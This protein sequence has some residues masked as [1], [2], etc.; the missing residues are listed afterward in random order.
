VVSDVLTA[1]AVHEV[2]RAC[3]TPE[4][5]TPGGVMVEGI[6][7]SAV[8]DPAK[9]AAHGE[10]I[11]ALLAELP[12]Q[13]RA[14][15]GGGWSFLNACDDRHGNQWTGFHRSMEELFMVGM[16][17]GLVRCLMPRDGW[18]ALPGGM[19]YYVVIA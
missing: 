17:A 2:F 16:A 3:L 1:E 19:P 13:F 5:D 9:V 15:I 6:V 14:D 7:T 8:F 11:R 12:D 10:E 18:K 4:A